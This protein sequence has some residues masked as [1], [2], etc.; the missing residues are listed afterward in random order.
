M[1]GG[2]LAGTSRRV[3]GVACEPKFAFLFT[4]LSLLGITWKGYKHAPE[5]PYAARHAAC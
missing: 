4:A 1:F 2:R 3:V 5:M